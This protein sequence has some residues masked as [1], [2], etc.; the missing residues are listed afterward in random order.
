[1]RAAFFDLD[2]TVI[3]K[4]SL[5]A[6][7]PELH[8]RGLLHRRTLI[9]A[10]IGQLWF[11]RF[12]ADEKRLH[13]VRQMVLKITR[14]W[15]QDEVR[16]MVKETISEVIEPLLY[17][18]ALELIDHHMAEGHEVFLVSS[19]PAEIVEPF[20]EL[21][22]ITGAISS[23]ALIDENGKFTGEMAFFAQGEN[24]AQ[25]IREIAEKRGIDLS[26][27]FAYSDSE[28]DVPMLEVVGHPF[29]VNADRT[30]TKYAHEHQWP[31]LTFSHPVTALSR[32]KSHTPF[33]LSALI[34][35]AA[36]VLGGARYQRR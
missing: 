28:T 19:A 20:A 22:D 5:V 29:A 26:E 36:A 7:G 6:L 10:G 14:G 1:M 11:Q 15:D 2:K 17:A 32:S 18:E 35:G 12:G 34:V 27:S 8:A 31:L 9:R 33:L 16:K 3:A 30:L 13:K 21:L 25:A 4:S 24:K 23:K